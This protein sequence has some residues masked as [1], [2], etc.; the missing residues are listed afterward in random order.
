MDFGYVQLVIYAVALGL[1]EENIQCKSDLQ[2]P[3]GFE[4]SSIAG[5]SQ[6][7]IY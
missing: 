2:N 3:T 1:A 5:I 7:E 4:A 6:Y